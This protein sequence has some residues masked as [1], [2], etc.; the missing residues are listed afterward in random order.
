MPNS[1]A[2]S[3]KRDA[4]KVDINDIALFR[5][6]IRSSPGRNDGTTNLESS[7]ETL[8]CGC[9]KL[10]GYHMHFEEWMMVYD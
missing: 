2:S 1:L 9:W 3:R 10:E 5:Q 8:S 4:I 7:W 6:A